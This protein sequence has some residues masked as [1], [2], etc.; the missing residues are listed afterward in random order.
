MNYRNWFAYNYLEQAIGS[1]L[2]GV[3]VGVNI[4]GN[5]HCNLHCPSC[6]VENFAFPKAGLMDIATFRKVL[7]K[8]ERELVIRNLWLSEYSEPLLHPN[9][10]EFVQ[11]LTNRGMT[12]FISSHLNNLLR[13]DK[14]FDAGL[15][16]LRISLSGFTQE[17]YGYYHGGDIERV[18]KNMVA[19]SKM[20]HQAE[21]TVY[22]HKYK[23]NQHELPLMRDYAHSLGFKFESCFAYYRPLEK[24]LD[25][26]NGV[27]IP[28]KDRAL[29][30][31]LNHSI[32]ETLERAR[33]TKTP[34]RGY[35]K[36]LEILSDGTVPVCCH[37]VYEDNKLKINGK[38]LSFLD[39]PLAVIRK[40]QREMPI[41]DGCIKKGFHVVLFHDVA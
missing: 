35:S 7:D 13:I 39:T 23:D 34:C 10:H 28:D 27:P 19:I 9:C 37:T 11:E 33:K 32:P 16:K 18:K 12:S 38:K 17:F 14:V 25:Y 15:K 5:G 26:V 22:F 4:L 1:R 2:Y 40:I 30:E 8:L 41:C 29:I 24:A 3:N 20:P 36:H 31:R 21:V 6:P